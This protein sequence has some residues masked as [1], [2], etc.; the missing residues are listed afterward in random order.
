MTIIEPIDGVRAMQQRKKFARVSTYG[1][2]VY[3]VNLYGN[4][5]KEAG[6]YQMRRCKVG[7][8]PIKMKFY[9]PTP[10][11]SEAQAAGRDKFSA[12]VLAWQGLTNEQK[13]VYRRGAVGKPLSG[14]NLYLR[15]YMLS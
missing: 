8:R 2:E 11:E 12:A 13:E 1:K 4:A 6:I 15:E 10:N 7:R 9:R 5:I 14:Y 3:G